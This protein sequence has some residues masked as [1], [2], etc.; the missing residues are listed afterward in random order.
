[1]EGGRTRS[2]EERW[3]KKSEAGLLEEL[4]KLILKS[5]RTIMNNVA[6]FDNWQRAKIFWDQGIWTLGSGND[7]KKVG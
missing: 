4:T 3:E 6:E 1:M 2:L 7:Y 5:P